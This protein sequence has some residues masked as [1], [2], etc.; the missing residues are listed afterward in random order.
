MWSYVITGWF[1]V[2]FLFFLSSF[3][4][5]YDS[6]DFCMGRNNTN[7]VNFRTAEQEDFVSSNWLEGGAKEL[8][9]KMCLHRN[10]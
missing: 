7:C 4:N 1:R 2:V 8:V 5:I 3:T 6:K 10:Q 9:L